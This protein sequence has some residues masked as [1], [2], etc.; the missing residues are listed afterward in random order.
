MEKG[1]KASITGVGSFLPEKVLTNDDLSKM[2]DTTDEW[3]TKRTGIRERR[4]AENEVAASDLAVEASVRA[5]D[6]ANVLPNEV[7]LIITSTATPDCLFPS[8][9]CYIQEKLGAR[10][11]GS[12]DLL[13]ACS[14]FVY[15][16]SVAKSFVA[17]G[18]MKT[19]LVVGSECMSKIT[20]YTDRSTCILFGDGAGAVV[21]QQGNGRREII[22]T[23]LGS[24]GSQAELLTLPA[25]GSKLPASRETVESRLHYIKLRGKEV[26]KQAIIN[27]VDVVIKT[28]AENNMRVEDF[29]MVIP[30]QSNI[31][32]IEA[33]ME[34]LGLPKEKAYI[35]IDRYGNTSSA[36]IPIAIDEIEKGQMLK[37]GDMAI[38]VAFG[39]GLTWGS[40]VI[41][42]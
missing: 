15:A 12:F 18:A 33:A 28:A 6:A 42:W 14:G 31:R 5:L 23:H 32:I 34:K 25:G 3:I 22:T 4:I 19:V 21:V 9:S 38:L 29:D 37:P 20:D 1:Y 24:D 7:D 35:N 13:A 40:S 36:S 2:L 17:S 27:M 10:N 11:A 16:L 30:H 26:F 39:G 41:K 8:T